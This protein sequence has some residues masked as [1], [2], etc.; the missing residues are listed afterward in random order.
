GFAASAAMNVANPDALIARTNL[1]RPRIDVRYLAGLGGDAVPVLVA[2][3]PTLRPELRR[4]LA[5]ALLAR[6]EAEGGWPAWNLARSRARRAL[7]AHH[8]ELVAAAR[9]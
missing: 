3:L 2:R 5:S 9:Q 1:S 8:A 7:A 6:H 4:E